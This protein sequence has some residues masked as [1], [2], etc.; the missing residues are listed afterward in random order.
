[1]RG[2]RGAWLI[3]GDRIDFHLKHAIVD[4]AHLLATQALAIGDTGTAR[5]AVDIAR[6]ASPDE[7][8]A[9]LDAVAV[10][11]AEGLT[12]QA[13]RQLLDDV[14]NRSDDGQPPYDLSDRSR[15]ILAQHR[16]W[17]SRAS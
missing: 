16:D 5:V 2:S 3:Q 15:Q 4:V 17:L 9:R 8:T 6:L 7:E 13:R 11:T 10:S 14:C 12:E 1:M